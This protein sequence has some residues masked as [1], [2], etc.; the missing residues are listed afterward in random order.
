MKFPPIVWSLLICVLTLAPTSSDSAEIYSDRYTIFLDGEIR[1]GD[2]EKLAKQLIQDRT[3]IRVMVNSPGGDLF[4]AMRLSE[5]IERTYLIVRVNPSGYCISACFFLFLSG[6]ERVAVGPLNE[7]GSPMDSKIIGAVGV[8]RPYLKSP[9]GQAESLERQEKIIKQIREYLITRSVAQYLIDEMM[10]RPSTDVY[11]LTDRD[12]EVIGPHSA[13]IEEALIA[14]CGYRR[15]AVMARDR[16][17]EQKIERVID[18]TRDYWDA[19]YEPLHKQFR[20][21]LRTGWR[22]WLAEKA[23]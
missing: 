16:W 9:T 17:S 4:E 22:P 23:K 6:Y 12:L 13:S 19:Q 10:S 14:I 7:I 5:L 15:T 1:P 11:W 21:K 18:C 8:H 20:A 3:F 2:A